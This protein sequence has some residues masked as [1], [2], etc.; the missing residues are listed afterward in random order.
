MVEPSTSDGASASPRSNRQCARTRCRDPHPTQWRQ[1]NYWAL[2]SSR[3]VV[4]TVS[5]NQEIFRLRRDTWAALQS[6][7]GQATYRR[8][9]AAASTVRIVPKND[10]HSLRVRN[11]GN[12]DLRIATSE[13][14]ANG[15]TSYI[16]LNVGEEK[17]FKIHYNA[18]QGYS[19]SVALVVFHC[20]W[21]DDLWIRNI[22]PTFAG[23][24]EAT[25]VY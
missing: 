15:T 22:D 14:S 21:D 25:E 11:V 20:E 8:S 5:I 6:R 18:L 23:T 16:E 3:R 9:V 24:I 12:V 7:F 1:G 10:R 13:V 17:Y 4:C 19:E 2:H